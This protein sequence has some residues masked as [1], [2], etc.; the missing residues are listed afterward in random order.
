MIKKMWFCLW[1]KNPKAQLRS[2]TRSEGEREYVQHIG[3]CLPW[4]HKDWYLIARLKAKVA[5]CIRVR[6][7]IL[8]SQNR[9]QMR[10]STPLPPS[11]SLLRIWT[12]KHALVR[13]FQFHIIC[14]T[15]TLSSSISLY[16]SSNAT[17]LPPLAEARDH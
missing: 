11:S 16:D 6:D 12:P 1:S 5:I 2:T 3:R 13:A 9:G 14:S 10:G 8:D 7:L 15:G 17:N 4:C